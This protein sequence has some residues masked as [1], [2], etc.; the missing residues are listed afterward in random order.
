MTL[1]FDSDSL[2][3]S[4]AIL[5]LVC[6]F[7]PLLFA[8][9]LKPVKHKVYLV[10][11][12]ISVFIYYWSSDLSSDGVRSADTWV[13]QLHAAS[14]I[15]MLFF[16]SAFICKREQEQG[17]FYT[18]IV[19]TL[20][21][22][23]SLLTHTD[24]P[25]LA[26]AL[27]LA[28]NI[29]ALSAIVKNINNKADIGLALCY[30]IFTWLLV[31]ILYQAPVSLS[32][33]EFY[34]QYYLELLVYMP[35]FIC[36]T[37][38]FI[39]LRYVIELNSELRQLAQQDPLTGLFN[40]RFAFQLM[41]KQFSLARRKGRQ[42]CV[43]MADIDH[44]KSVNDSYGHQAGDCAIKAFAT[45]LLQQL[46]EYDLACRYGGEEFLLFLPDTQIAQAKQVAERIREAF[47]QSQI[48]SD[49]L[50]FYATASFGVAITSQDK[51]LDQTIKQADEALYQAK[52]S[53]RNKVC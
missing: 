47:E 30:G 24:I 36:G 45:L 25:Y 43:I 35:A 16:L 44:F 19:I 12:Y 18:L 1:L 8:K 39:V 13:Q 15:F 3:I 23:L 46:R 26:V 48:Q 41:D 5:A 21:K 34:Q 42:D 4:N 7:L 33:A 29:I 52:Q 14:S 32:I 31:T 38:I 20:V 50:G 9:E 51:T 10:A 49:G 2:F 17:L 40:R 22:V 6:L 53:G 28:S 37:T 11:Y 27:G